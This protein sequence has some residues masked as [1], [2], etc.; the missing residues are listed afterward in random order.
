MKLTHSHC[1]S[2]V[3]ALDMATIFEGDEEDEADGN[4]S[5]DR[6]ESIASISNSEHIRGITQEIG[7]TRSCPP[8]AAKKK[9]VGIKFTPTNSLFKLKIVFF[10]A[11]FCVIGIIFSRHPQL[12][13]PT[14]ANIK[15][16]VS[17]RIMAPS[18]VPVP[19][20]EA[21]AQKTNDV[22]LR[23]Q[24]KYV[25]IMIGIYYSLLQ[26]QRPLTIKG[27]SSPLL[28]NQNCDIPNL[29]IIPWA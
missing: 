10:F 24:E 27:I 14:F 12:Y 5:Q 28:Y 2:I 21:I 17:A 13:H 4:E 18:S 25:L 15:N 7:A 16:N 6:A 26:L 1:E 19:S 23:I 20:F 3:G 11:I 29:N 9:E 22:V 8:T